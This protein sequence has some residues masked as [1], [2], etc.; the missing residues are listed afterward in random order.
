M[1]IDGFQAQPWK[2]HDSNP[3]PCQWLFSKCGKRTGIRNKNISRR[4]TATTDDHGRFKTETANQSLFRE[5]GVIGNGMIQ[6]FQ[7]SWLYFLSLKR[8]MN[9]IFFSP[10]LRSIGKQ[11]NKRNEEWPE[12]SI[13]HL[14]MLHTE[15]WLR[16]GKQCLCA[17]FRHTQQQKRG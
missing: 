8:T 5:C 14:I 10:F 13:L 15:S 16:F 2:T 17:P 1:K 6:V 9:Y 3:E 12:E 4:Q 7:R 11:M